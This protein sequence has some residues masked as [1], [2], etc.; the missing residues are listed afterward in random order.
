[1]PWAVVWSR[2]WGKQQHLQAVPAMQS[3]VSLPS[4]LCIPPTSASAGYYATEHQ[5]R[6]PRLE[7]AATAVTGGA[8]V[9]AL[10]AR[11]AFCL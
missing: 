7:T 11:P 4:W 2:H 8:S 6:C 3:H 1:M 10:P 5:A 9:V